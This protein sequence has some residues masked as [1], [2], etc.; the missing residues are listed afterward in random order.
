MPSGYLTLNVSN[1]SKNYGST[2]ALQGLD[3]TIPEG[4]CLA[5][6]GPNGAGKTTC[7]DVISGLATAD[8]GKVTVCGLEQNRQNRKLISEQIGVVNQETVLYKKFT[9]QETLNLF[10]SFYKTQADSSKLIDIFQLAPLLQKRLEHLSGGQLQRVYLACGLVH[11]PQLLLLDEPTTGLDPVIRKSLWDFLRE[12]KSTSKKSILL[13]THYMEEAEYLAD[14][15]SFIDQGKIVAQ[16]TPAELIQQN[17][18]AY[19]LLIKVL[20]EFL[21]SFTQILKAHISENSTMSSYAADTI[22]IQAQDIMT[23]L[24]EVELPLAKHEIGTKDIQ[25]RRASLDDVFVKLTGR[26]LQNA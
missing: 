15:I 4:H 23:L 25:V 5:L 11:D 10:A 7:C 16:G 12:F 14:Q 21:E 8:H 3:F 9:V 17:C 20:P 19:T 13:T 2:A 6:L 24:H 26:S 18:K 22:A 1:L